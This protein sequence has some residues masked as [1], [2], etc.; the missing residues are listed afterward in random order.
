[1]HIQS[2]VSLEL[3]WQPLEHGRFCLYP[4]SV[5]TESCTLSYIVAGRHRE[6][7]HVL[8][9]THLELGLQPLEH[10]R[11][12]QHVRD[13]DKPGVCAMGKK[14]GCKGSIH[15]KRWGNGNEV[16][17]SSTRNADRECRARK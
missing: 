3:G 12:L 4:L 10:G 15:T 6:I 8:S 11:V 13:D 2:L 9:L 1:M 16:M 14:M 5:D 7:L 17:A